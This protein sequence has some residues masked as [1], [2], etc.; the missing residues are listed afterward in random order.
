[1][2]KLYRSRKNKMLCGVCAGIA[3]YLNM[4]PTIIRLLTVALCCTGMG[5][6]VYVVA[7]FI[8]PEEPFQ[9]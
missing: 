3:D 1:M 4:D 8:V 2:K 7:A 6:L 9:M 5:I